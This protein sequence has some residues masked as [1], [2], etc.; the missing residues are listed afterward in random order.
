MA[1]GTTPR[2]PG[3]IAYTIYVRPSPDLAQQSWQWPQS[4]H[5]E[6]VHARWS[7]GLA[8]AW[9]IALGGTFDNNPQLPRTI[10]GMSFIVERKDNSFYITILQF[11]GPQHDP[12]GPNGG[13]RQPAPVNQLVLGLRG[14]NRHHHLVVFQ[15]VAPPTPGPHSQRKVVSA[16]AAHCSDQSIVNAN[17]LFTSIHEFE[18]DNPSIEI[19][20]P[21]IQQSGGLNRAGAASMEEL[22]RYNAATKPW[23]IE[24]VAINCLP[25]LW[26]SHLAYVL[27]SKVQNLFCHLWR[28]RT[29]QAILRKHL[30]NRG[31]VYCKTGKRHP[32]DRCVWIATTTDY[33]SQLAKAICIR[34]SKERNSEKA[35]GRAQAARPFYLTRL[36]GY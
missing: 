26:Q 9:C 20:N 8:A 1:I 22:C 17:G 18:A 10:C 14:A 27:E 33:L 15:G 21:I 25:S 11:E 6:F 29:G 23:I 28:H 3:L 30:R 36:L 12:S 5:D 31:P 7:L 24:R 2:G 32:S 16:F 35:K 4:W 34:R 13:A 19:E